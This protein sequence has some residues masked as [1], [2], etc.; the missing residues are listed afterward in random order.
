[1]LFYYADLLLYSYE[2]EFGQKLLG[3]NNNKLS[4][5]FN[6]IFWYIDDVLSINNHNFYNYVRLIY[7]DEFEIEDTTESAIS[8]SYLDI[9][10]NTDSNGRLTTSI[11]VK[12]GNFDFAIVNFSY[13]FT[14]M[15]LPPAY[16]VYISIQ[17]ARVC[18]RMRTF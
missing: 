12:I 10:L 18:L 9:L 15:P 17:Y 2:A 5:S 8:A 1:V 7:H 14:N 13:L 6:Q 4:V 11:Y 16:G 3:D